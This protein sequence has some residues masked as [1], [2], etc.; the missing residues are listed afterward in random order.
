M[1]IATVM[2]IPEDIK[3]G[4]YYLG[5]IVDELGAN[6][7]IDETNNT[8]TRIVY[9]GDDLP[10]LL[11]DDF[12][13]KHGN[14]FVAGQIV[15][16]RI[17]LTV[18][19]YGVTDSAEY[20]VGF[21]ISKDPIITTEDTLLFAGRE[22]ADGLISGS[23]GELSIA[24]EMAIPEDIETGTYFLGVIVDELGANEELDE[25]NNTTSMLI[26]IVDSLPDLTAIE[27]GL[28]EGG[29][30][31]V[32]ESFGSRIVLIVQNVGSAASASFSVGFYLSLDSEITPEDVLLEGG[33]EFETSV[34][35]GGLRE[36]DVA[37]VLA[38]PEGTAPGEYFL[39][40][41]VDEQDGNSE[42][43]EA[44]N[45]FIIPVTVTSEKTSVREWFIY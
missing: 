22:F 1:D 5:V 23:T 38:I 4:R 14:M 27:F 44:N 16:K 19:N 6:E 42:L 12:R 35:Q 30:V 3:P 20:A 26:T 45:I 33:R 40:V 43:D 39:G 41:I 31:S 25:T 34:D 8:A 37:S 28:A 11:P 18:A 36:V 32:G 24:H 7:E 21:Y 9:I 15:G 29:E 13:L 2:A 10:D 17:Y